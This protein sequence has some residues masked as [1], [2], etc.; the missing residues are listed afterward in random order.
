MKSSIRIG[1]PHYD[2][3]GH[4]RCFLSCAHERKIRS[5]KLKQFSLSLVI[6][7]GGSRSYSRAWQQP[8]S[9]L[10]I[11]D[12][13]DDDIAPVILAQAAYSC[14]EKLMI[15]GTRG[16]RRGEEATSTRATLEYWAVA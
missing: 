3:P 15:E 7:S 11:A 5:R 13:V 14:G 8:Y 12:V 6:V 1:K 9:L 16:S 4:R 2:T 10:R